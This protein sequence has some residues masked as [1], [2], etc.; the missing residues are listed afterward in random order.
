MATPTY[1]LSTA[2]MGVFVLGVAFLVARGRAWQSYRPQ[3]A[4][5]E[6]IDRDSDDPFLWTLGFI[7]LILV[8]IGLVL[9]V[10]GSDGGAGLFVAAGTLLV[11]GFLVTGIY[12]TARSKGR[13]Q[14]HAVGQAM[15]ALG[16]VVLVA[17]VGW[18]LVTAGA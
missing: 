11:V 1:L 4:I 12:A 5:R 8:V 2:L 14:S 15:A 17:I 6:A 7:L 18:L 3:L 16:A 10:L 9:S 13:P